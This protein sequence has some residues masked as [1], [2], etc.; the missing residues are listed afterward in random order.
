MLNR[1]EEL[2]KT[3]GIKEQRRL[4]KLLTQ[5]SNRRFKDA[6]SLIRLHE[7]LMFML[8]YPQSKALLNQTKEA[9][10]SFPERIEFLKKIEADLT[11]L[12]E[13]EVSG[14]A[15]TSVTVMLGYKFAHWLSKHHTN[16][17]EID[18]GV[19][20]EEP[21]LRST[22][23]L[24]LPLFEEEALVEAHVSF[25]DYIQA[26][27]RKNEKDLAWLM[28]AFSRLHLSEKEKTGLY[29]SLKLFIQFS[30][31]F[32]SSR[33]GLRLNVR[34]VFYHNEPLI[35]RRDIS[36]KNE[37]DAP[38]LQIKKLSP[39]DALE[40]IDIIRSASAIRFRELHGFIWSDEKSF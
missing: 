11:E 22:L 35:Q 36:L 29:D 31:R 4:A 34:K 10:A 27:K 3:F 18:W 16:E 26:A 15:G 24:V 33:T 12:N 9:L 32:H 28:A 17:V 7:S 25:V 19:Y 38:A 40:I 14:I 5:L 21:G 37:M 23:P 6:A 8:A 20:N 2:K 13:P 1:L 30:P 39:R